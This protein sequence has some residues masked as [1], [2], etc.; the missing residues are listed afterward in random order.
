MLYICCTYVQHIYKIVS[1]CSLYLGVL[2]SLEITVQVYNLYWTETDQ[3]SNL[4]AGLEI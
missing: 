1:V 3:A 2:Y 4:Y